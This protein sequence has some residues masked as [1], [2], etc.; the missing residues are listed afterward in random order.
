[1]V[2]SV[3][4]PLGPPLIGL[5]TYVETARHGAWE[6]MAALLPVTYLNAVARS[7]GCALML[8]PMPVDA[9]TA[10]SVVDGLVVTGGPDVSPRRYHA[11][12]HERTDHPQDERD[13]WEL[14]LCLGAL[15][16]DM[17]LLAVCRG[18]QVLNVSLGGTLHQ[19]LPDIVGHD[20]H[21]V[22]LGQVNANA[23]NIDGASALGSVL[24]PATEGYCHHHQ[25]VARLGERL[26]AVGFADD[27]TVE[28][29]EVKDS[30]FAIGVQWHPEDNVT[31]D[32]LFTALVGAAASYRSG[33]RDPQR[34]HVVT[35]PLSP[36]ER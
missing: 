12:P 17:P 36:R 22:N 5:S 24:G 25:A 27:G 9:M 15:S 14:A 32:R 6:E 18:V 2:L 28:A 10:L 34:S 4:D 29:V 16:I 21:R 1:V 31:D 19:H 11:E 35:T 20:K 26:Q 30:T 7:G 3:S 23:V 33:I 8:P 13:S